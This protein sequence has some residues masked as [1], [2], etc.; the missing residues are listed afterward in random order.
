MY[1]FSEDQP[2]A[3]CTKAVQELSRL[4][5]EFYS[6]CTFLDPIK[7]F[8]INDMQFIDIMDKKRKIEE[9]M[10]SYECINCPHFE[11]HVSL[12][13]IFIMKEGCCICH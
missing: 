3:F 12:L 10:E 13:Y 7:H 9:T 8:K 2:S 5:E 11:E 1:V 4:T 6:R